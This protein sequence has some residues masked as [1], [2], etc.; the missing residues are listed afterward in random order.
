MAFLLFILFILQTQAVFEPTSCTVGKKDELK[1][2]LTIYRASDKFQ[3]V[4]QIG[5]REENGKLK[6]TATADPTEGLSIPE[7]N[8]ESGCVLKKKILLFNK[9]VFKV[10]EVKKENDLYFITTQDGVFEYK[11]GD[12][13]FS[14][15]GKKFNGFQITKMLHRKITVLPEKIPANVTG[16]FPDTLP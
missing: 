5:V 16:E 2:V 11:S 3:A 1:N 4:S 15:S 9:C 14:K 12:C 7:T 13:V 10:K 6:F 8:V